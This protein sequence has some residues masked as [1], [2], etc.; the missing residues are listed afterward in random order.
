MSSDL[1]TSPDGETRT[2]RIVGSVDFHFPVAS[3]S[4]EPA[5]IFKIVSGVRCQMPFKVKVASS[6]GIDEQGILEIVSQVFDE[7][8]STLSNW[9]PDSE[10]NLVNKMKMGDPAHKMSSML[11]EVV[12]GAKE[13]VKLTKGN[14]DPSILPLIHYYHSRAL[15]KSSSI[16]T[17]ENSKKKDE[18]RIEREVI[19][20]WKE[21][22]KAGYS[23]NPMDTRI[24]KRV[25]KLLELSHWSSAFSVH[26]EFIS[27]KHDEACLDL[28]GI[29]KGYTVDEI[30]RRL[31]SPCMVEWGGD[32]KVVGKHPLGKNVWSVGVRKPRTLFELQEGVK[33]VKEEG[34]QGPV[35]T[36]SDKDGENESDEYLA[37]LDLKDGD[38]IATR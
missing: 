38:A 16:P 6:A 3:P 32:V 9:N 28:S 4:E 22:L 19:N 18:S 8:E 14:F 35:Y 21:L 2:S 15:F 33:R 12:L 24:S 20:I 23:S 7:V 13:M 17:H 27:K 37:I 25:K 30:A 5:E 10:V 1:R 34:Q 11:C 31:P 26:E 29:A 36:L